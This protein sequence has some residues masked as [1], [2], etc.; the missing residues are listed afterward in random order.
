MTLSGIG[1]S[2]YLTV[3]GLSDDGFGS[4]EVINRLCDCA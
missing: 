2:S 4:H 3:I 1:E